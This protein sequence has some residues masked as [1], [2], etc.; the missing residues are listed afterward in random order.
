MELS[1]VIN[2]VLAIAGGTSVVIVS[3]AA[4]LGKLWIAR[5]LGREK[6]K[7]DMKLQGI[8]AQLDAT[9]QN[10]KAELDKGLHIHKVQFDKEF[11]IYEELWSKLIEL[12]K[13]ALSLR[14]ELDYINPSESDE[15]RKIK[16]LKRFVDSINEF[17]DLTDKNRP[18]YSEIVFESMNKLWK[19]AHSE[20]VWYKR[21]DPYS[22]EYWETAQKNRDE[23]L[24]E[25]EKCCE[26][27]RQRIG[28]IRVSG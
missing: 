16:R 25:I 22:N 15:E 28:S 27:I 24:S 17:T 5:V 1:E 21:Q 7:H 8:Q 26:I 20:S 18:F 13:A 11:E 10:L 19:L 9:N 23:I 12:R 3:L 14:P 2:Q 4:F 6:L